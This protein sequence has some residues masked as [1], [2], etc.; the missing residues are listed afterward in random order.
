MKRFAFFNDTGTGKTFLSI[1]LMMYHYKAGNSKHNLVLVPN[2]TNKFE[3]AEEGFDKHAPSIKYVVLHGSSKTKLQ[4]I[5]DNPDAVAFIETYAGFVRMV[6]ELKK[7]VR[8][9]KKIT[10][11]IP[12]KKLVKQ[13]MNFF[14]GVYADESTYL[15]NHKA[16]PYRIVRQLSKTAKTLFILSATPFN[17]DPIDLWAQMFLVDHGETLGETLGLFRGAFYDT[18][19]NYWGGYEYK[20][21]KDAKRLISEYLDHKSISYPADEADLPH[22]TRLIKRT[23][24]PLDATAYY[25]RA[26][27]QI[28]DAHGNYNEMKNAFLRMR[29]IS[30]GFLGYRDDETGDRA[31]FEFEEKVKLDLLREQLEEKDPKYKFIV[32]HEFNHS[33]QIICKLLK[34]MGIGHLALNGDTKDTK[35][36]RHAFKNDPKKPGL[37]LSNSAGGYGLNLQNAKYGYYYESPV[38]AILRKQTEKRFDRQ[39]SL[40][41]RVFIVDLVVRGTADET[42]LQF[43]KEGRNMWK[44]IMNTG[45]Q[46]IFDDEPLSYAA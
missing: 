18:T 9:R 31:K 22:V 25:E 23:D 33:G 14:D 37:V 1:A 6:C 11:L 21:K 3:W 26:K 39:Y 34:D 19:T 29:Q 36:V 38:S 32:F 7:V 43:H 24:L 42:I 13:M 46:S 15:R 35:A 30:S 5:A 28:L 17:R 4:Q 8:R 45:P 12:N 16:L 44:A 10:K 40:H 27:S 2:K 41:K 20:L